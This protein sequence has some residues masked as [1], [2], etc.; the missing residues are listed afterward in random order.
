M[1]LVALFG[2]QVVSHRDVNC[3]GAPLSM[4]TVIEPVHAADPPAPLLEL[5]L[6]PAL[7]VLELLAALE[8]V[9]VFVV[10]PLELE[11][12]VVEP[13]VVEPPPAPLLDATT[14]LPPHAARARDPKRRKDFRIRAGYTLAG[15]TLR[16][17]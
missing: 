1:G 10:V 15:A 11:A 17:R 13:L 8:V 5:E 6:E 3:S 12:C 7:A 9:V 4:T 2:F 14:V 16:P